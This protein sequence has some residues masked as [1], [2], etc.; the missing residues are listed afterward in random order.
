M[1]SFILEESGTKGSRRDGELSACL[2]V[3][4]WR[5]EVLVRRSMEGGCGRRCW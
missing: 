3:E 5:E 4:R 1:E 2:P